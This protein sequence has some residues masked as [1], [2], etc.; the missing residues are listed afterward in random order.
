MRK[1]QGLLCDSNDPTGHEALPGWN[2]EKIQEVQVNYHQSAA[3]VRWLALLVVI[4]FPSFFAG[5]NLVKIT[6]PVMNIPNQGVHI[7]PLAVPNSKFQ[8]LNPG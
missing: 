6:A 2:V 7:T 1:R 5:Q 3:R 4:M 8:T